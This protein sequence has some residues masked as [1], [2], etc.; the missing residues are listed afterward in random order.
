MMMPTIKQIES[1][2]EPWGMRARIGRFGRRCKHPFV[3]KSPVGFRKFPTLY[4]LEHRYR[5][6]SMPRLQKITVGSLGTKDK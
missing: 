5:F 2:A 4:S 1:Q 6:A 3:W